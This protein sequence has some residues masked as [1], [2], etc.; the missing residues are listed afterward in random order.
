M[1]G[2]IIGD[3]VGSRFEFANYRAK[4]FEL[5]HPQ[6]RFTDDTVCTMAVADWVVNV[7]EW[8]PGAGLQFSRMLQRW[9]LNFPLGDYGAMFSEWINNPVPYDS[10]GNGS[11]MRVSPVAW[12]RVPILPEFSSPA[13]DRRVDLVT[14]VSHNHPEGLKG[15]RAVALAIQ[16]AHRGYTKAEISAAIVSP[17]FD[18]SLDFTCASIRKINQFD[19]TCQVTVPQA[20]VCFLESG[21]FEDCIRLAVSIG[22]DSDTIAA[23][24]GSIAEA[25]YGVS[26]WMKYAALSYLPG[27]MRALISQFYKTV[28][29]DPF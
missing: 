5:F 21:G 19:E 17:P 27:S 20:L 9:C 29:Y 10:F 24:A 14:A 1:I 26:S 11:A 22:G 13:L 25:Y 3:I 15:A 28:N 7:N 12:A 6:C 16:M 23:I 4:N 18:Y 8:G 2:A